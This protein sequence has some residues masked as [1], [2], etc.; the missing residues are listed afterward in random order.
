MAE[1]PSAS[2]APMRTRL[3]WIVAT[4]VIAA[5]AA[6]LPH[7]SW[8][9]SR[10]PAA[11]MSSAPVVGMPGAPTTSADGLA[12]RISE[13]EKRLQESPHDNGAA[14]LLADALLRQARVTG[15]GRLP[16]RAGSLLTAVLKDTPGHYEALR[17]IGAVYLAQHRFHDAREAGRRA[18]DLRP[19][20]AWNYGVIGDASIE[21]GEYEAAFA[22]FDHMVSIR[23]S[24][25]AYARVAYARELQGNL[26]RRPP[27]DADG[28][29]GNQRTRS[30]GAR[31]VWS[32]DR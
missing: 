16:A 26:R 12:R 3:E 1:T 20:D 17:L 11:P 15:D 5:I 25:G 29:R 4:I 8:R 23:P 30:G 27:R 32:A 13:M 31:M 28:G 2:A 6:V 14:V 22:A 10:G 9:Q 18:R 19:G 24:A 7:V 21:L